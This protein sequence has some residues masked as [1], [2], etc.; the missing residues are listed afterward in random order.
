MLCFLHMNRETNIFLASLE[1]IIADLFSVYL[2]ADKDT[3]ILRNEIIPVGFREE[4]SNDIVRSYFDFINANPNAEK[5]T[6]LKKY[7]DKQYTDPY[8]IF[9]DIKVASAAA[10]Q[11]LR[12]RSAEYDNVDFF[13]KFATELLLREITKLDLTITDEPK[14]KLEDSEIA[15]QIAE[16]F[17]KI[18]SSYSVTNG[19]VLVYINEIEEPVSQN[20]HLSY[21]ASQSPEVKII[22]QPLF[23][24]L[25]GKSGVDSRPTVIPDPY[26]LSKVIPLNKNVTDNYQTLKSFS[27]PSQIPPPNTQPSHITDQIFH[28]SWYNFVSSKWLLYRQKVLTP[29]VES[30]LIKSSKH[31]IQT[32]SETSGVLSSIAPSSDSRSRVHCVDLLNSVWLNHLGFEKLATIKKH[33]IEGVHNEREAPKEKEDGKTEEKKE[34]HHNDKAEDKADEVESDDDIDM[35]DVSDSKNKKINL[36]NVIKFDPEKVKQ[37]EEM[38]KNEDQISKSP[39]EIQR[40]ISTNLLKLNKLRQQRILSAESSKLSEPSKEEVRLYKRT[41]KLT[42]LLFELKNSASKPVKYQLSKKIPVLMNDY[43]GTLPGGLP[44]SKLAPKANRLPTLSNRPT[45]SSARRRR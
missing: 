13:Y 5:T 17:E 16:G 3:N 22:K 2:K 4:N 18:S 11:N 19:E 33:Y 15:I 30:S 9:H 32:T 36:L 24:H 28:P 42:T 37:L 38:K 8:S 40:L 39:R 14:V 12:V 21:S 41:E 43:N 25:V 34:N 20:T 7:E 31:G 45:R 35:D 44:A 26:Q 29:A 1:R 23:T 27:A 6:I 10:I